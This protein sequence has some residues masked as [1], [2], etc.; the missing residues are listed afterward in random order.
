M[1]NHVAHFGLALQWQPNRVEIGN[2]KPNWHAGVEASIL[3]AE[4]LQRKGRCPAAAPP[5]AFDAPAEPGFFSFL[6]QAQWWGRPGGF[7][8]NARLT[9]MLVLFF[10]CILGLIAL[11]N[12][13]EGSNPRWQSCGCSDTGW[14]LNLPNHQGFQWDWL[15]Y[16]AISL[17]VWGFGLTALPFMFPCSLRFLL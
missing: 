6:G 11:W 8:E 7:W 16:S 4:C 12:A 14:L 2:F 10:S 5:F 9:S 15:E 13:V 3:G 1:F 17:P